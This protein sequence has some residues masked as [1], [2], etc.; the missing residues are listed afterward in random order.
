MENPVALTTNTSPEA[1]DS[2][3]NSTALSATTVAR[4][5]ADCLCCVVK[6]ISEKLSNKPVLGRLEEARLQDAFDAQA[7]GIHRPGDEHVRTISQQESSLHVIANSIAGCDKITG[8]VRLVTTSMLGHARA[9]LNELIGNERSLYIAGTNHADEKVT[10]QKEDPPFVPPA[11]WTWWQ[12][13]LRSYG[14]KA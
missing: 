2:L 1:A 10:V 5:T 11:P 13:L 14:I 3:K 4:C 7:Y 9:H 8:A 12:R 6:L